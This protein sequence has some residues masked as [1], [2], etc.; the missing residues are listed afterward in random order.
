MGA[1]G[2]VCWMALKDPSKY[3]R[4][5]ELIKPFYFLTSV[6]DYHWS[7][8]E[9]DDPIIHAPEYLTGTYG[10]DQEYSID[11]ALVEILDVKN[12]NHAD[13]YGECANPSIL[14]EHLTFMELVEDLESRPIMDVYSNGH[15]RYLGEGWRP[16]KWDYQYLRNCYSSN[17]IRISLLEEMLWD[18]VGWRRNKLREALGPIADMKIGEWMNEMRSLLD[19]RHHGCEETWT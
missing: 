11:D 7:N 9:W 12:Y 13:H 14:Y 16:R 17:G 3:D 19:Y 5:L 6:D 15:W 18:A 8:V 2:G 1:D 10:T 4:V